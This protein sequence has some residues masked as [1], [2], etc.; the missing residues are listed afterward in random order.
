[1]LLVL[2]ALAGIASASRMARVSAAVAPPALASL[3][4]AGCGGPFECSTLHVPLDYTQPDGRQLELALT[5]RPALDPAQ[6]IGVL[7]INPGGPG[8]SGVDSA[9][10]FSAA[11]PA[12]VRQR[13]DL[14]GF[15]PRGVGQSSPLLCHDDIQRLAA[16]EPAPNTSD[17]WAATRQGAQQ[18]ATLCAQRADGVLP[19]LGS[20]NVVRDMERIRVALGEE[21]LTYLGYSYGTLLGAL[22]AEQYPSRVRAMVLDGPVDTTLNADTL[23][24]TQAAG[25]E[26][27]FA[28]F[29]EDCR[30]RDCLIG[31]RGDPARVVDDLMQQLRTRPV[32][33]KSADRPAGPGE[34]FLAL[35]AGM[36]R[37]ASW[38]A[39]DR[40]LDTA[41][42]GD[43]SAIVNIAD[44][45]LGRRASGYDNSSEM[46]SAVNCLDYAYS[47]DPAHYE[48]LAVVAEAR[49]PRFG[50]AFASGG[51]GCAYWG[52]PAQPLPRIRGAGAPPLLIIATTNDPATPF[53]WGLALRSQLQSGV[54]L[55]HEGDG[56]T[57]FAS[58]NRCVNDVATRY[59]I[60]LRT[61]IDGAICGADAEI[62]PR[63][64]PTPPPSIA[65]AATPDASTPAVP[66]QSAEPRTTRTWLVYA[67]A[68]LA[69][70]LPIGLYV[71]LRPRLR[72]P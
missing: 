52:T 28:R 12:E 70:V 69:G 42:G 25:F 32:A 64:P 11:L 27:A 8:G 71:L 3:A 57:A 10:A 16:L 38:R 19:H 15:D 26:R 7:V 29:L 43:G 34:A 55:T 54:L 47:H 21:Q 58:T 5:R 4:W 48:A 31:R 56:H 67:L 14:V 41:L 13:F 53:E 65:S 18:A 39:L 37:P 17:Q 40:A 66:A 62:E 59:L 6:R 49:A 2:L 61:P 23:A 51:L 60:S 20:L 24:I 50:R 9:R 44:S 30:A 36:Y 68:G 1:M 63:T 33:S 35:V 45:L 46:N 22:Y 72:R